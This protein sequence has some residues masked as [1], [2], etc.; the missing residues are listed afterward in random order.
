[1]PDWDLRPLEEGDIAR[2]VSFL[3]EDA[4]A[5][6]HCSAGLETRDRDDYAAQL[7]S[8]MERGRRAS[9]SSE[10]PARASVYREGNVE[11]AVVVTTVFPVTLRELPDPPHE[12]WILSVFP[13]FRASGVGARLLRRLRT[14]LGDGVPVFVRCTPDSLGM[15]R[16]LE[17]QGFERVARDGDVSVTFVQG[18][19]QHVAAY[20][21]L[22]GDEPE[23]T[24]TR[25]PL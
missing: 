3:A 24:A 4:R 11:K 23:S 6:R 16:V 20:R 17:G 21:D 14:R 18:K 13:A 22:L 12:L 25:G 15:I 1:M 9:P 8:I 10:L 7:R 19:P 5:G 2:V